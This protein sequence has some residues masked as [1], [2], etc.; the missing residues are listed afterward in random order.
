MNRGATRGDRR[1]SLR[2]RGSFRKQRCYL[3]T[4]TVI[5]LVHDLDVLRE[6]AEQEEDP[7]RRQLLDSMRSRLA[8]RDRGAKVS[9]AAEILGVSPPTVR[10]WIRA[11]VLVSV[12][13]ALPVRIDLLN[14]ADVKHAVDLLRA[15]GEDRDLLA[16]VYRILRDRGLLESEQFAAGIED[17]RGGRLVPI[18][19]DLRREIAELDRVK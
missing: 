3:G 8:D 18:G 2:I 9:E 4:V 5:D 13:G 16:A 10:S 12:E 15:R 1:V 17:A 19:D 11:G 14:L 7:E 6:L